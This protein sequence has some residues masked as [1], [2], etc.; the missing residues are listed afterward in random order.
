MDYSNYN[1]KKKIFRNNIRSISSGSFSAVLLVKRLMSFAFCLLLSSNF[2]FFYYNSNIKGR[3]KSGEKI[4]AHQSESSL[5]QGVED[6]N[7]ES[8]KLRKNPPRFT[9]LRAEE[10]AI[11]LA[12]NITSEISE[13][14]MESSPVCEFTRISST[15]EYLGRD[16]FEVISQKVKVLNLDGKELFLAANTSSLHNHHSKARLPRILCIVHSTSSSDQAQSL[17]AIKQTWGY[18]YFV[19]RTRCKEFHIY[20]S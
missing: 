8:T 15:F 1:S 10:D 7:D 11:L 18:V 14:P 9:F 19:E 3:K 17:N 20:F 4:A 5:L 16:G 13:P 6:Q 2:F 12:S